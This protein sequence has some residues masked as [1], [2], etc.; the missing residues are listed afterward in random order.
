MSDRGLRLTWLLGLVS[1]FLVN[2]PTA[3]AQSGTIEHSEL[4]PLPPRI[5]ELLKQ[6]DVRLCYGPQEKPLSMSMPNGRRLGALTV[7]KM[8]YD[9]RTQSRVQRRG[10]AQRSI[11]F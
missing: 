7:Y 10:K 3:G 11:R 6:T 1:V 4:P 5:A 9:F 8:N 2:L